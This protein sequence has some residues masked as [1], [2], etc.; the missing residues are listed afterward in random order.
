M[1]GL[2]GQAELF[3]ALRKVEGKFLD[4]L[5]KA[6]PDEAE[7]LMGDANA[8]APSVSGTLLASASVS[9]S[10]NAKRTKIKAVAAYLDEK[11]AA[12]HEGIHWGRKTKKQQ[13][14]FKWFER[15]ING[16]LSGTASRIVSRLKALVAK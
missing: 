12:V 10:T 14:G 1:S 15:A 5:E 16:A 8:L 2:K 3:R 9:S 13:R 4:E 6:L 11:A 7:R